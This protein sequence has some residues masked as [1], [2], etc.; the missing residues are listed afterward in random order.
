MKG[1]WCHV[2][3][4]H[5]VGFPYDRAGRPSFEEWYE[6]LNEYDQR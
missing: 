2:H 6:P 3:A 5:L 1:K 4:H